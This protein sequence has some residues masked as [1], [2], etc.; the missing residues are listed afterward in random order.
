MEEISSINHHLEI[1]YQPSNKNIYSLDKN[2]KIE[3]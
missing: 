1:H 2:T 3:T